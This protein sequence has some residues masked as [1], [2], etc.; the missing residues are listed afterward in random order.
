MW[1]NN[2][3]KPILVG[4][5]VIYDIPFLQ[6]LFWLEGES[7][8]SYLQGYK[9]PDGVFHPTYFDTM[10]LSRLKYLDK[11]GKHTLTDA[12]KRESIEL[13]DA[14][15]AEKD[16]EGTVQLFKA[17]VNYLRSTSKGTNQ[18]NESESKRGHFRKNF[19]F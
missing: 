19:N 15:D 13:I 11:H 9:D 12:C 2:Y 14:H 5:N 7:L 4:H 3:N 17:F 1:N 10:F 6:K 8:E 18:S 16:T